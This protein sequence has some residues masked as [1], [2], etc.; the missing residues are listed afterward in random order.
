MSARETPTGGPCWIDLFSSD[1]AKA[2]DFYG[3]LFGWT[4]E[5]GGPEYYRLRYRITPDSV[6]VTSSGWGS[7]WQT[8]D[9]GQMLVVQRHTLAT[10]IIDVASVPVG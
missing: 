8:L 5:E 4:A 10:E 1:T 6:V 3:E 9:N 7:G 2:R